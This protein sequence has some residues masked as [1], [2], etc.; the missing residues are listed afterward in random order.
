MEFLVWWKKWGEPMTAIS[1]I[2]FIIFSVVMIKQDQALKKEISLNCGWGE[3]D[4]QCYCEKSKSMEIKNKMEN[5]NFQGLNLGGLEIE[6]VS[7][8]G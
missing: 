2:C 6:N 8:A 4:Y 1:I 7:M 5:G 3:E